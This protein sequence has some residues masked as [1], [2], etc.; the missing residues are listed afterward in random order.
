MKGPVLIMA[1]G[2]GGHVFPALAV[3]D[4]LK[5]QGV[6]VV[7]LGTKKGIESRVVV[8]AGYEIRWLSVSGLRGKNKLSLILAPFK[9]L[10][11]CMQAL[12]VIIEIK[13]VAV[14]GMGGFAS[15][16]GG[17]MA[18]VT[19]KPL[20]VHEQNAIP[21]LTNTLLSKMAGVV[22]ES[23][24]NSFKKKLSARLIGNPVRTGISKLPEP[25]QRLQ[26][27]RDDLNLLVVGGSLGAAILNNTIP[28]MM[29]LIGEDKKVNVWHQTGERNI[30]ETQQ[31]YKKLNV[32][33]RVDAFINDMAEAYEWADVVVCR[34]GAMTVSELAMAGVA[35]ILVPYPF[36][37][38]DHQ[39]ANAM[40]L[41][42]K[43]AA[44]LMHQTQ[45][46]A[47]RLKDELMLLTRDKIINMSEAARKSAMPDAADNVAKICMQ[48][49]GLV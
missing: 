18:Y 13:P 22:I 9:L 4:K 47:E 10:R 17:L 27:R 46:N 3:A 31:L 34:S 5:E 45:L 2:T 49:G 16:P 8:E 24:P 12:K 35:S 30:N 6:A 38:D 26:D 28:E 23:F 43:D 44:I 42:N 29:T 25:A 15:G 21:G 40:Y 11:A 20:L 41:V 48:A 32:E 7:W 39:T 36:A 14:L 37:V 19:R 33:A 1:G